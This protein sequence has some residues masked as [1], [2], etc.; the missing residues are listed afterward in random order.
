MTSRVPGADTEANPTL[1][2]VDGLAQLSFAVQNAL[3]RRAAER[4]LSMIQTRLLG[5]LR[6][7]TPGINELAILLDL[8][9]SSVSGLVDRAERRGLVERVPSST[10][11]RAVR[12]GLT[13][14]GRSVVAEVESGFDADMA[15]LLTPLAAAERHTLT[16]LIARLLA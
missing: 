15:A 12:V 8:D 6:D 16:A 14:T 11:R 9:K 10:D 7:R 1:P 3:S 13:A 4:D 2:L 5:V